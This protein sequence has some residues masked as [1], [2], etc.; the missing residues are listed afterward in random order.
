MYRATAQRGV[1]TD[2]GS[3]AR[4][5]AKRPLTRPLAAQ[6]E[7]PWLTETLAQADASQIRMLLDRLDL[8]LEQ[9]AELED[10]IDQATQQLPVRST[11]ESV[12]GI[13]MRQAATLVQHAFGDVVPHRDQAGIRLGACPVFTGSGGAETARPKATLACDARPIAATAIH[14]AVREEYFGAAAAG[15]FGVS[16]SSG[17]LFSAARLAVVGHEHAVGTRSRSPS[18]A[19]HLRSSG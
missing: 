18:L 12:P 4:L 1:A 14:L 7:A 3:Q 8:L 15:L 5:I 11:L 6:P 2:D 16:F 10:A 17:N 19:G 13:A 9:L